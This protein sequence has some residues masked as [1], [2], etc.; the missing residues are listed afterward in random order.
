V[1]IYCDPIVKVLTLC[2][3]DL[4]SEARRIV[5]EDH[6]VHTRSRRLEYRPDVDF[7]IIDASIRKRLNFIWN[8]QHAIRPAPMRGSAGVFESE[9]L[10]P[11]PLHR[12]VSSRHLLDGIYEVSDHA[13]QLVNE[14]DALASLQPQD[15]HPGTLGKVYR[16][17]A[18]HM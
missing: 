18:R 5:Y 6:T 16:L 11:V 1:R 9:G 10:V 17:P 2:S 3:R 8:A 14:L 7:R 13:A 4:K 15:Y 12:E